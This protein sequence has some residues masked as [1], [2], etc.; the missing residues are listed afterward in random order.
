VAI[1]SDNDTDSTESDGE[2]DSE[3]DPDVDMRMKDD[4]DA[5]DSIDLDGNVD[6][7]RDGDDEEEEDE[8]KE[9]EE[10]EVVDEDE[11]DDKNEDDGKEPRTI[12]QG[13]MVNTS[14]DDVD[15]MVDDQPIVLPEQCQEM[16][17]HAPQSQPPAP[18]PRPQTPDRRPRPRTPETHP[19][20][21]LEHLEL[22]MPQKPRRAVPTQQE[23]EAA[24]NTSGVDVDQQLLI[25]S[26]GGDSLPD[27]PLPDV[28]LPEAH[29]DGSVGEEWTSPHVADE[30]MVVSF[31]LRSGSCLVHFL[32]SN[33]LISA[34]DYYTP[35]EVFGSLKVYF[36]HRFCMGFILLDLF[37]S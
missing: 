6:M 24:G 36:I 26:G 16:P 37:Y 23:A 28:P 35:R 33:L 12:G 17:E 15:T 11:E 32:L 4:V 22:V 13:E 25:E 27:V 30:A 2:Y 9:D 5:P 18:A 3:L 29:P 20:S 14:A 19:L 7:E 31:V 21:G 8:K 1:F 34:I 10:E